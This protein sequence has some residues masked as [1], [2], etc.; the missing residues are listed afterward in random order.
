[1]Q[2]TLFDCLIVVLQ[3]AIITHYWTW[4]S[5]VATWGSIALFFL[6][7]ITFNSETWLV[8]S[9]SVV[10]CKLGRYGGQCITLF[11]LRKDLNNNLHTTGT[12]NAFERLFKLE[13]QNF[14]SPHL[15][16]IMRLN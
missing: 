16:P 3:L 13:N 9:S 4:M 5:H 6:T 2:L 1:M 8:Q 14:F 11:W 10:T 12:N 15:T 7:T